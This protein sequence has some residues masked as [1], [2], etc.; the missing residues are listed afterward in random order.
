[1]PQ[2]HGDGDRM[3]FSTNWWRQQAFG[4]NQQK[5]MMPAGVACEE[6]ADGR[7]R[8]F[9]DL[10]PKQ[11]DMMLSGKR[12]SAIYDKFKDEVLTKKTWKGTFKWRE[13]QGVVASFKPIFAEV[14]MDVF[15][16]NH[17]IRDGDEVYWFHW[18]EYVD[19]NAQ[20]GYTPDENYNPSMDPC[21][22]CSVM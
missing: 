5:K 19:V 6:C 11:V 8:N 12:A 16:C 18:F 17:R 22:S 14:G 9:K 13:V 10:K 21:C 20:P 1:M 7:A 4:G 2:G 15:L 3:Q